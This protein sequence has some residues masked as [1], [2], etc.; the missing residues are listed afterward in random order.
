MAARLSNPVSP[1]Y[2]DQLW[3]NPAR[4]HPCRLCASSF[5]QPPRSSTFLPQF[6]QAFK[7]T[8]GRM[9]IS[10]PASLEAQRHR[11]FKCGVHFAYGG[12]HSQ[13]ERHGFLET[14]KEKEEMMQHSNP[15]LCLWTPLQETW[16]EFWARYFRVRNSRH[17]V[18]LALS[19]AEEF[20]RCLRA[21][22]EAGGKSFLTAL[23]SSNSIRKKQP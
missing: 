6:H 2:R 1:H 12:T 15:L 20:S 14:F 10:P 13:N 7:Q 19:S 8:E 9:N 3:W 21:S 18:L 11:E 22:S 16:R 5:R 4:Q 23:T 17:I